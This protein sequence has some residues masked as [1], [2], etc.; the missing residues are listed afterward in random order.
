MLQSESH[1]KLITWEKW[2]LEEAWSEM[3]VPHLE[4][5]YPGHVPL[6]EIQ[7]I[8]LINIPISTNIK[9]IAARLAAAR[10]SQIKGSDNG[11]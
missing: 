11:V 5:G 8:Q 3:V 10:E 9:S 1:K 6:S 2:K 7:E 4:S